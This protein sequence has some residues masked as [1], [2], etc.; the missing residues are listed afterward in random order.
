MKRLMSLLLS[1][2][3]LVTLVPQIAIA[4]G[5]RKNGAFTYKL[6]GNGTAVI[7]GYDWENNQGKDI[8]IP[9]RDNERAIFR[10]HVSSETTQLLENL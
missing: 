9:T 10:Q 3:L 6:K 5:E 1:M 8:Y 2:V 4:D 7:T